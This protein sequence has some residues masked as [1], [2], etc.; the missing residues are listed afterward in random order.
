V[1]GSLAWAGSLAGAFVF[2]DWSRIV[3]AP[4]IHSLGQPG[5]LLAGTS[6]PILKLSLALNYAVGG[7]EV[8]GYHLVNLAIHLLAGL[9]LFGVVQRTLG[10]E[11]LRADVGAAAPWLAAAVSLLWLLHP[12][13]TQAVTYV[14]QRGEALMGLCALATLY[15][16]IRSFQGRHPLFWGGLAVAT[17]AIGMG[18]KEVMVVVPV[19]VLL[20]DRA[21]QSGSIGRALREHRWLHVALAATWLVPFVWIG[22][23]TLFRGEFAR[24]ELPTPS[25]LAYALTQPAIVLHYLRLA[26]WP[27]PLVFDYQWPPATAVGEILPSLLV[28]GAALMASAWL[29]WRN[30]GLGFLAASFFIL[31]APSSSFVPIQDLAVEHR[32]YLP[33]AAVITVVV[34]LGYRALEPVGPARPWLGAALVGLA[35][36]ALGLATVDRNRDYRDELTLW[37]D[38]VEAAP[39]NARALYNLA[40]LLRQ[41]GEDEAA[42][43]AFRRCLELAPEHAKAHYNLANAL[44]ERGELD[45]AI[46]HY[47]RNL[48]Q[49]P[50]H[51]AAHVNL[52]NALWTRGD[53]REAVEHYRR[54]LALDPDYPGAHYNLGV[55]LEGLGEIDAA[56]AAYQEA[57]R[58]RPRSAASHNNLGNALMAQH[59]VDEAILHYQ[60]ANVVDSSNARGRYNLGLALETKGEREAAEWYY[61]LALELDPDHAKARERLEA[62]GAQESR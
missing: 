27:S 49:L 48:A 19:L 5:Q 20:H 62:A 61:R 28:I 31:L 29:L 42:I 10:S 34:M 3:H 21:F 47:G 11:R 51:A 14:V 17:C 59:R 2:D 30:T 53:K 25:P 1:A 50:D 9:A 37:Q 22:S 46:E 52:G 15:L 40:T 57:V 18:T 24:P 23:E 26:F 35:A 6:R 16:S 36:T 8:L 44:K 54:A 32:M 60:Q 45:A 58:L 56:I 13:Q 43:A 12:L 4:E 33:L 55:A 41:R 38:V 7:E 39:G